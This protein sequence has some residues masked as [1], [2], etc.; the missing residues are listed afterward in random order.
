MPAYNGSD[1]VVPET[2]RIMAETV[3]ALASIVRAPTPLRSL[4]A[5]FLLMPLLILSSKS[6]K[7]I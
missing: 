6:T 5:F 1:E 2:E 3:E 7:F 4:C